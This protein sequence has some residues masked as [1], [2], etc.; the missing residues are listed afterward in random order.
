MTAVVGPGILTLP[1]AAAQIA[2]PL[3]LVALAVL[4]AISVP[5]AFAFVH[6][7]RATASAE[8]AAGAGIQHYVTTAFGPRAGRITAAWFYLGVPIGVPALA[9]IGGAYVSAAVGGGRSTQLIAAWAIAGIA[10]LANLRTRRSNGVLS[11]VLAVALVALIVGAAVISAPLWRVGNLEPV[12]PNGV[13]AILPASLTLMWVLTGWEA[14]TNF[15]G[16]VRDPHR[17][18]PRVIGITLVAV[19]FLYACVALPEI[20]VLGPFAGNTSAPVAAVLHRSIGEPAAGVAAVLAAILAL[21]NSVAYLASLRELGTGFLRPRRDLVPAA[22]S[23]RALLAPAAITVAGLVVASVTDL[24]VSW[25]V[26]V[27]AG[28][29]IPV[30]VTAL[31]S[32]LVVLRRGSRA[33]W[34]ALV[35]TSTVALL[36]VPAGPYLLVPLIIA[37]GVL[38]VGATHRR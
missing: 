19:V 28:S 30:Y 9:L 32:G 36:L 29:Q 15:V 26:N 25:F 34:T 2:G 6:I 17:R 14:S 3:S 21:A 33:W 37:V 31:A 7:H 10:L 1:G 27:C 18:L 23:V 4:L 24:D 22:R 38:V 16:L 8:P 13:L 11:L 5:S 12:A 35:A 20:L